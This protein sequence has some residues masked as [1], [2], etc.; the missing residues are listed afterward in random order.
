MSPV[1]NTVCGVERMRSRVNDDHQLR[2]CADGGRTM[3]Y[4][5]L[6]LAAMLI[7]YL[8]AA[9]RPALSDR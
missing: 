2:C 9:T 3:G 6:N 1:A 5:W 7:T 4:T 8:N